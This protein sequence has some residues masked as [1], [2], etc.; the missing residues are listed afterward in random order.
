MG[1]PGGAV[2]LAVGMAKIFSALPGMAGLMAYWYQF[3][4][5][6]EALFI[7]TTIDAGTRVARYLVQEM[8]GTFY[9]SLK[10]LTWRPGVIGASLAVVGSWGYL[11]AT[12]TV[13]TIWPMFGVANQLLGML[14]LCVGTTVLIK[15]EKPQYLWVTAAPM[16]FV[17]IITLSASYELLLFFLGKARAAVAGEGMRYYLDAA[18]VGLVV[19]LAL[20][21]LVDSMVKWYGFLIQ[22]KPLTTSEGAPRDSG[23]KIPAGPCC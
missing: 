14:A 17:G 4:L 10:E 5:L 2:S 1:R 6:F 16:V 8:G 9:P 11:L 15:M 22:K 7:L 18:L 20:I 19:V 13:S 21:A 3:A 12:G 23:I